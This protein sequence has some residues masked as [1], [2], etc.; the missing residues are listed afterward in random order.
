[1]RRRGQGA[2]LILSCSFIA[3]RKKCSTFI[4]SETTRQASMMRMSPSMHND[5]PAHLGVTD[6]EEIGDGV[7]APTRPSHDC[8]AHSGAPA[9]PRHAPA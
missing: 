4:D 7:D 5:S 3:Q 2:D 8:P 9:G 6:R 1:M